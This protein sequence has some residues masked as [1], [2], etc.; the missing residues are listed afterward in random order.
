V[1]AG[2][3]HRLEEIDVLRGLA[4]LWVVLSHYLPHWDKYLGG[5]PIIV[6]NDFG[7][8][9]VQLF[10]VISGFVI[11]MTLDRCRSVT[12][13]AVLRFSRLYPAYWAALIIGTTSTLIFGGTFWPG[14]VLSNATMFQEFIGFPHLD[15]VF[16]S[17]SVELA[18]YMNAAWLFALGLHRRT[19]SIVIAWLALGCLWAVTLHHPQVTEH[20]DWYARLLAL[21][22][23]PYFAMGIVFFDA[24]THRWSASRVGLIVCAIA[25]EFLIAGWRGVAV[26]AV[27]AT[28]FFLASGGHLRFLVSKPTL[29]LGSISY[30]LYLIHRNL[31]YDVLDWMHARQIPVAVAVPITMVG[32]M[33]LATALTHGVEKPA[34][35]WIRSWSGSRNARS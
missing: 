22:Y 13:F 12:E 19:R 33:L 24:L 28:L 21:D 20:R 6:P 5:A 10:F 29:W 31:G 16:W 15:N 7:V 3:R 27:V 34:L 9:A 1:S 2:H 32:V 11:F 23:A 18:F 8:Y 26:A 4:A 14:G 35:A 30:S 25:T 17:L